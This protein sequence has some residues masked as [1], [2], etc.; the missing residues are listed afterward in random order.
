MSQPTPVEVEMEMEMEVE[1]EVE[2]GLRR[3][4][5]LTLF[6][7]ICTDLT[8]H[9]R[10]LVSQEGRW[11]RIILRSQVIRRRWKMEIDFELTSCF[12]LP[13]I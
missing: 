11:I 2:V 10:E 7:A 9:T 3:R 5:I 12:A 6:P 1:V 4:I 8:T 13:K